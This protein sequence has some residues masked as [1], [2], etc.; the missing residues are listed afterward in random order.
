MAKAKRSVKLKRRTF[1]PNIDRITAA[2]ETAIDVVEE[3][4]KQAK[5]AIAKA[6]ALKPAKG[7]KE[8]EALELNEHALLDAKRQLAALQGAKFAAESNCCSNFQDCPID[9]LML[10]GRTRAR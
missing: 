5:K 10:Q 7:S 4:Q 1:K 6:K 8:A 3:A 2:I 9:V